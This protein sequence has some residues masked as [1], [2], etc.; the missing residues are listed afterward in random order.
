M[1]VWPGGEVDH[2]H[3]PGPDVPV[4]VP[5]VR[6]DV[7]QTPPVFGQDDRRDL[8]VGGRVRSVVVEVHLH[9]TEEDE[10]PI[11]VLLVHAPTL[12][13]AGLYRESVGEDQRVLVPVPSRIE[14]LGDRAPSVYV[15]HRV[16]KR[17]AFGQPLDALPLWGY[18]QLV[19]GRFPH[20]RFSLFWKHTE[21]HDT[22][23]FCARGSYLWT[24]TWFCSSRRPCAGSRA[25]FWCP[26]G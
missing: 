3:T 15:G 10:V 25:A 16:A 23:L 12:D 11:F 22:L 19:P 6:R 14:E 18:G 20:H 17:D 8:A 1:V 2:D 7:H 4:R 24:Q 9:L 13:H 26:L 5:D 21:R